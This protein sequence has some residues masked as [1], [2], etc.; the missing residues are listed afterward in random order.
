MNNPEWSG[1]AVSAAQLGENATTNHNPEGVELF[2]EPLSGFGDWAAVS[3]TGAT[4]ERVARSGLF[5]L[6]AYGVFL[7]IL[8]L[9]SQLLFWGARNLSL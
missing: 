6:N 3:P 9:S 4:I 7:R 2:V 1:E 5:T 8:F